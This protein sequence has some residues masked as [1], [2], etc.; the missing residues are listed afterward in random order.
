MTS[1]SHDLRTPLANLRAMVE[2]ITDG[3]VDDPQ[4]VRSYSG[5]MLASIERLVEMVEDLLNSRGW[6]SSICP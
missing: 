5:E 6:M 1:I 2:A 4:T 3:V